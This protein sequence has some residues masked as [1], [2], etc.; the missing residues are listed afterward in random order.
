MIGLGTR[1]DT[2]PD[3]IQPKLRD[4]VHLRWAVERALGFPWY[5]FF[6][7]R[8]DHLRGEAMCVVRTLSAIPVGPSTQTVQQTAFGRFSSDERLNFTDQFPPTPG[9]ELDLESRKF[10]QFLF[11]PANVARQVTVQIGFRRGTAESPA[12]VTVSALFNGVSVAETAVLGAAGQVVTAELEADAITSLRI[13]SEAASLVELCFIPV[14]QTAVRG[15]KPLD[16]FQMP[17]CLPVRHPNYPANSAATDVAASRSMALGRITYGDTAPW[18][19]PFDELHDSL[20]QLVR[21]GPAGP[22]MADTTLPPTPASPPDPGPFS[23]QLA[24]LHPLD[25][26]LMGALNRAF[27]EIVGLAFVDE[28]ALPNT[29]YDYLIVASHSGIG[30]ASANTILNEIASNNFDHVDAWIVFNKTTAPAAK[31]TP[32][33]DVRAFALPGSTFGRQDGALVDATNNAGLR[34]QLGVTA[35]A[36]APDRAVMYHM[37]RS[38]GGD[39][40][41]PISGPFDLATKG[42]PIVVIEPQLPPG[43]TPQRAADW[44]PF[45]L[46]YLDTGLP[47]GWYGYGV[48]GIDIFGRHSPMSAPAAWH[49]WSPEPN[50]RPWYYV[51]P[52]GDQIVH[53]SAVRLLD[54]TPPPPP[55]GIEAFALDSADP[56]VLRDAA[57]QA[58]FNALSPAEQSQVVGLR[59]RWAWTFDHMR[60]APDAHEFRLYYQAGRVNVLFGRI[61]T[62]APSTSTESVVTTDIASAEAADAFVGATLR[63]GALNFRIVGSGAGTPLSLRVRN[64]GLTITTGSVSVSNGS[65]TVTGIG[66]AWHA[67]ANGLSI[68]IDGDAAVYRILSV[69]SPT[70][71][72]LTTLFTGA[73]AANAG[74][75]IFDVRP[76]VHAS[77]AVDLPERYADGT[78]SVTSGAALVTGTDT[79]WN[80]TLVGSRFSVEGDLDRYLVA[81]VLSPTQLTLD[82]PYTGSTGGNRLYAI[83]FPLFRDYRLATSWDERAYVVGYDDHVRVT[84]DAGGRPLRVYEV[85]IPASGDAFRGGVPLAPSLA[86]PVAYA[87]VSVS[88]A[89]GRPHT[90]DAAKWSA[91]RYGNRPGNEGAVGARATIFRVR[92]EPPPPP[93]PSPD[94]P[95]IFATPADY[96]SR[97]FYTYRWP[98]LPYVKTHV[99]RAM[100]DSVFR[101]DWRQRPRTPLG[102][103]ELA[104]FP[105]DARWNVATRQQ[106]ADELNQ[107]NALPHTA[108]GTAQAFALYRTLSNDGLRVLAGLPGNETAFTQITIAALDSD[109]PAVAD[110]RGPDSL[111]DYAPDPALRAYVDTLDGRATNRYFYRAAYVDGANNVSALSLSS[112]PIWLPNVVAPRAPVVTRA[113]GGDRQVTIQWASNREPDLA[114][115]RLYRTDDAERARD[116]RLM[117]LVHEE[118][119]P[120]GDPADRPIEISYVDQP[121]PGLVTL[122]YR[123]VAVDAA[124]NTSAPTG[125]VAARAFDE[126]LPAPPLPS[127]QWAVVV[128]ATKAEITWASA[129]DTMLQRRGPGRSWLEVA[130]W[131]PPGAY[132]IRDPFSEPTQ[133]YEYRVWARKYTGAVA[134]GSPVT[135]PRQ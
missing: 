86:E 68:V 28:T 41:T 53:P 2:P 82:R 125:A 96:F 61:M 11:A 72:R 3:D 91:G 19:T 88:T 9:V 77:I 38:K 119:V 103:G 21:Q 10:L 127:A 46:H 49:E 64:L 69:D 98:A 132:T 36:L 16:H 67:G 14:A 90:A 114:N 78:V 55:T 123:L 120:A 129:D 75:T 35:G 83:P 94:P 85:L 104:L 74:Y 99:Y 105:T 102:A 110:R 95:R 56:T 130:S 22:A 30:A 59:V 131:R 101:A 135:L 108:D 92:R 8:R 26:V 87:Q 122:H 113:L 84:T 97:S 93:V 40:S 81:A 6:L 7:F 20:L 47:E 124:G 17:G 100:D 4:G 12:K 133:T 60:Q 111:A 128:G 80:A 50:P 43:M 54:K 116:L 29:R 39:G 34:W 1:G 115:Y 24:A 71:L 73:T 23:P 33:D 48:A 121:V 107:L 44:P 89:D 106:V 65:A 42:G 76:A 27:A 79:S 63:A 51:D 52:P 118:S 37:W 70:S 5:G 109:D 117:M 62:V 134:K 112:A 18:D 58:W 66:T 45:P 25:L 15:W 32:P 31:L 126:S 13:S 57:Y